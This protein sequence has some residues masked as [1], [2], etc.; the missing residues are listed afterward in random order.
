MSNHLEMLEALRKEKIV[1]IVRGLPT[2]TILRV[3]RALYAGGIRF[4]EVTFAQHAPNCVEDTSRAIKAIADEFKDLYVG[5]GTV[6]TLEQLQAAHA[7]GARYMISPNVDTGLI[8][9]AVEMDMV[10]MSGALTP[11]EAVTAYNAG[12]TY[13]KIF[14]AGNLGPDYIKAI[15]APLSHI[16]MLAVGGV[17]DTNMA[18]FYH[19][20]A[21]GFGIG[22]CLVNKK[23]IDAGDFEGL[24]RLASRYVAI[25]KEL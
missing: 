24:S 1:A 11:T 23:L 17:D 6:I 15:C 10:V 9:Q 7:A 5:A 16:P 25:A 22:G 8:K 20:G 2:D 19:A 3:A 13:V 12:S 14:P 4:I 21:V 18:A